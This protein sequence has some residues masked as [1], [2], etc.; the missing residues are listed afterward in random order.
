MAKQKYITGPLGR[1][2]TI[3]RKKVGA[4]LRHHR[5]V[6]VGVTSY[7][8]KREKQHERKVKGS[9]L[10]LLWKTRSYKKI[11]EAEKMLV[12]RR[13]GRLENRNGGG[14]GLDPDAFEYFLYVRI[15]R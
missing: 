2:G 14:G 11:K 1:V 7:P 13:R 9:E 6:Y 10:K 5:S 12:G 3:L 4:Y 15:C 8:E